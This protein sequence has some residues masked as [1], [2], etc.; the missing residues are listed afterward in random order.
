MAGTGVV[1]FWVNVFFSAGLMTDG[2]LEDPV[3]LEEEMLVLLWTLGVDLGSDSDVWLSN[4]CG[5]LGVLGVLGVFAVFN[6]LLGVLS[7]VLLVLLG[8]RLL[9]VRFDARLGDRI[10]A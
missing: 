1:T 3:V 2:F 4:G 6:V 8:A 9:D 5:M 10:G 7:G